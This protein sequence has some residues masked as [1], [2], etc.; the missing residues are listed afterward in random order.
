MANRKEAARDLEKARQS[1]RELTKAGR[2]TDADRER[3][4]L[5]EKAYTDATD[6]ETK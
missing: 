3:V 5:A 2:A 6:A 1:N 4:R